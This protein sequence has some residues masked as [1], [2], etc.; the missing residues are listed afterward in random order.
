[1]NSMNKHVVGTGCMAFSAPTDP[2]NNLSPEAHVAHVAQYPRPT[3][4]E[5]ASISEQL[6][7]LV[8]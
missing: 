2:K 4:V 3:S 5:S 8:C 6:S 7:K 1:M